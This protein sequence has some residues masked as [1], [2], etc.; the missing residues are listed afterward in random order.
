[1]FRIIEEV[2]PRWVVGENVGHF[3]GMGLDRT[4]SDLEGIGYE[5]KSFVIPALA[6]GA[7]HRRDRTFIVAY[8]GS[9]PDIQ[10]NTK[11]SPIRGKREAWNDDSG[12]YWGDAAGSDWTVHP[13]GILG[14]DDG[15]P[16]RVDRSKSLGNA[17]M[18]KHI[19]PI[20]KAIAEIE[21][22]KSE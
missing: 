20:F 21:E 19:Y 1:M 14:V 15:L 17:V 4:L 10:K 7:C 16:D 12:S 13:S 8:S 3:V 18:P 6:V 22:V 2:R 5:W 9:K 11:I